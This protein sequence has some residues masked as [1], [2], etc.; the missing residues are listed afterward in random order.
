MKSKSPPVHVVADDE[1]LLRR[2]FAAYFRGGAGEIPQQPSNDSAV[3]RVNG[4]TYVVLRN[5]YRTLSV[6]RVK[7]DGLLRRLA[8]WPAELDQ[9]T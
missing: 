3:E 1:D 8:R 6:Y 5:S 7:N 9:E 4:L 2:G